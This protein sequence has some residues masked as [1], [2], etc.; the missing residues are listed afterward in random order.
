MIGGRSEVPVAYAIDVFDEGSR[1]VA[2]GWLDG[3]C[4]TFARLKAARLRLDDG[5]EIRINLEVQDAHSASVEI[6]D[7]VSLK[8]A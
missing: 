4:G 2:T 1:C 3:A 7:P 8:A 5:A 6:S